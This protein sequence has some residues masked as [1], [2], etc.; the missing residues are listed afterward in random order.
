VQFTALDEAGQPLTGLSAESL[1]VQV[2]DQPASIT[3]LETVATAPVDLVLAFDLSLPVETL[4]ALKIA[5][6]QLVADLNPDDQVAIVVFHNEVTVIQDFTSD[7]S[8]LQTAL[9]TLTRQGDLTAFN[10]GVAESIALL[11]PQTGRPKAV[12]AVTDRLFSTG[13]VT[14]EMLTDQARQAEVRLYPVNLNGDMS[15]SE[16]ESFTL[17]TGG[18]PIMALTPPDILPALTTLVAEIRTTYQLTFQSDLHRYDRG[19]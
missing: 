14:L 7:K 11:Q 13:Q 9:S 3:A 4:A 16:F 17:P 1:Q 15:L 19:G 2:D 5:A 6:D 18:R 8:I 12:L 10:E